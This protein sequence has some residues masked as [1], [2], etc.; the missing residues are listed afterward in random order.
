MLDEVD[1]GSRFV[2]GMLPSDGGLA[3]HKAHN[4]LWSGF[5]TTISEE[6]SQ[7]NSQQNSK[8]NIKKNERG[9]SSMRGNSRNTRREASEAFLPHLPN[10]KLHMRKNLGR[11]L[12][13]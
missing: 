12:L 6:N 10:R 3:S 5:P 7:Q 11:F 8:Q 4:H 13:G 9:R 2:R 1:Y